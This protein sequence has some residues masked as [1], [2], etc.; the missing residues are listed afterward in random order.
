[1]SCR[2]KC[3][4][5]NDCVVQTVG[6]RGFRGATGPT[7]PCCIGAT[8]SPG[9][10]GTTG[11]TGLT[12][13]TGPTGPCCTG[14]TG[15]TG[16]TGA[17]GITGT[18]GIGSIVEP[19]NHNMEANVTTADNSLA[20]DTP[21]A[22]TNVPGS[23]FGV[24]VNGVDVLVGDGTKI[25]VVAYISGDGGITAKTF[26]TIVPGD[27]AYWNGSVADYQLGILD[28]IDFVYNVTAP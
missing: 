13:L 19:A 28:R 27:Q 25:G 9:L 24:R 21:V 1:M 12:G 6:P 18:T 16:P 17:T 5:C 22:N 23:Y 2:T 3:G 14:P 11:P 20:T 4:K 8:G 26:S 10:G 7:G 15:T